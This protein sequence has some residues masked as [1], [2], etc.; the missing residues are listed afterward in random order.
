[1]KFNTTRWD[2]CG[3]ILCFNMYGEDII[4]NTNGKC[5]V[6]TFYSRDMD[7]RSRPCRQS[8]GYW[9]FDQGGI[10]IQQGRNQ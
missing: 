10:E 1:M 3:D 4:E 7:S 6:F 8:I 2:T 5:H 9:N